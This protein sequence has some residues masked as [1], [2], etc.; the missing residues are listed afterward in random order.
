[1]ICNVTFFT[2]LLSEVSL[3]PTHFS[4]SVV[5]LEVYGKQKSTHRRILLGRL[6]HIFLFHAGFSQFCLLLDPLLVSK[7]QAV[8]TYKPGS[9]QGLSMQQWYQRAV[10]HEK[11]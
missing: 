3:R 11:K 10:C 2:P 6:P 7:S 1:M 5:R 4:D 9:C 8:E